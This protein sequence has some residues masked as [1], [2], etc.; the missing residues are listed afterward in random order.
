MKKIEN[1]VTKVEVSVSYEA[2]DGK[3]FYSEDECKEYEKSAAC[4]IRFAFKDVPCLYRASAYDLFPGGSDDQEAYIVRPET[5]EHI[6]A[7]RQYEA[8]IAQKYDSNTET[9]V[10][11]EFKGKP[12]V[13]IVGYNEEWIEI[14]PWESIEAKWNKSDE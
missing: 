10:L 12:I 4:A 11:K 14:R 5:D 1:K 8:M 7:L 6:K 13:V 9:S 3:V 2:I